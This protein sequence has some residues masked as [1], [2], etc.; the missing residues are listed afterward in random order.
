MKRNKI[1]DLITMNAID[2]LARSLDEF[3]ENPKYSVINFYNAIELFVKARLAVEHWTLIV[4]KTEDLDI[5]RFQQGALRTVSLKD[6]CKRLKAVTGE[7]IP[8]NDLK[9]FE[10][11]QD[12]RNRLVHFYHAGQFSEEDKAIIVA[13]QCC[14]W[15]CL[16]D[17]LVGKWSNYFKKYVS[18]IHDLDRRIKR[19]QKYLD[20]IYNRVKNDIKSE[21]KEGVLY[22]KCPTCDYDSLRLFDK[23][24]QMYSAECRVCDFNCAAVEIVCDKCSAKVFFVGDGHSSCTKC[25]KKYSPKNLSDSLFDRGAAYR[26]EKD[27]DDSYRLGNCGDCESSET[28]ILYADKY[29]CVNCLSVFDSLYSCEFC[30]ELQTNVLK[31]SYLCGCGSCEGKVGWEKDD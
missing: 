8:T 17:L 12:H 28:V 7:E 27:G 22:H 10:K 20:A 2:F 23:D 18:K 26:A 29:L 30:H 9:Q 13:E 19:Q 16:Y 5:N 31:D 3:E 21:I 4:A 1:F 6:A 24:E 15:R 11:V 14:G 25:G